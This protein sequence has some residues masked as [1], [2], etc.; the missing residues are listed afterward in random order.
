MINRILEQQQT[1][2][3]TLVEIRKPE[4]MPTDTEISTMEAFVDVLQL[5]V[6]ITEKIGGEKQVTLSAVRPLIYKLLTKYLQVTSEDSCVKNEI[7]K[8][9][10][11]LKQI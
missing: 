8:A 4:L 9:V 7:R 5:I 6:E 3:A 1:L 2:C 11:T 10:K